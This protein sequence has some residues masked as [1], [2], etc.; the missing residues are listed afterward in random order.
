MISIEQWRARIGCFNPS[1][2][3]TG[4]CK[5][6]VVGGQSIRV[7]LRL[8]LAL[9]L[10]IIIA[11]D[12]EVNP[13]PTINDVMA[14]IK[15]LRVANDRHFNSLKDEISALRTD[16]NGIRRDLDIVKEKVKDTTQHID[17]CYDEC[18]GDIRSMRYRIEKLERQVENQERYSRRDN[19][20][21]YDIPGEKEESYDV[22]TGKLIEVLNEHTPDKTWTKNDFIRVHRIKSKRTGT[23]PIIARFVRSDSKFCALGSRQ[24]L[25]GSGYGVANDLSQVQRDELQKVKK[26]GRRGYWLNGKL[27][28]DPTRPGSAAA[29]IGQQTGNSGGHVTD[30]PWRF[31]ENPGRGF[32]HQHNSNLS[33]QD[34]S[35]QNNADSGVNSGA[36]MN[37]NTSCSS[38]KK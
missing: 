7:G 28:I 25:K 19:L 8:I 22:T 30:R 32:P 15:E 38:D 5:V 20:I 10:C 6:I 37:S 9:S 27:H 13:G 17:Q 2:K 29:E 1:R 3:K 36:Q 21:F 33:Q 18:Y 26:E 23:A 12:V 34:K 11:G 4:T 24:R 16:M 35:S 31:G 14:E